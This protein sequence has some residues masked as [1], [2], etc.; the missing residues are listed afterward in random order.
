MLLVGLTLRERRGHRYM[1]PSGIAATARGR[2]AEGWMA[3]GVG[4][5]SLGGAGEEAVGVDDAVAGEALGEVGGEGGVVVDVAAFRRFGHDHC[6]AIGG[7]GGVVEDVDF[8][9]GGAGEDLVEFWVPED[10]DEW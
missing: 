1:R 2:H 9:V 5:A 4:G 8:G 6:R 10:G 3:S 7:G